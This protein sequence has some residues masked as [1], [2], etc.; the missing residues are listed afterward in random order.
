MTVNGYE[1]KTTFWMDFS[2]A[3]HFGIRAIK[4]TYKRASEE[5]KHN[6]VYMTEL[7][8]VLNWKCWS[9]HQKNSILCDLYSDL[10]YRARDLAYDTLT[11]ENLQ[12][13]YRTT[14]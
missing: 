8:L 7:V 3:D 10:Y 12:Y 13:F 14:D 11:G 1:T 5:W 2:I 6:A 4:D 9:W